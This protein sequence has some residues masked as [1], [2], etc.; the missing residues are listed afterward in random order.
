[1]NKYKKSKSKIKIIE[2]DF[3]NEAKLSKI[4]LYDALKKEWCGKKKKNNDR[5]R[6]K[7]NE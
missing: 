7:K 3:L 4:A 2:N 1:M 6:R 5:I